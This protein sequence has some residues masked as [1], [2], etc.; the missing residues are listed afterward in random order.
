VLGED[1]L[2]LVTGSP[3]PYFFVTEGVLV[4]LPPDEVKRALAG[5]AERF[6]GAY[7]ALDTY[8]TQ[9]YRRQH[10]MAAKRGIA[11][12]Q[13]PCDDPRSLESLGLRLVESVSLTRPPAALRDRLP[14]R[15]R[16]LLPLAAPV[17]GNFLRVNL[18]QA[19]T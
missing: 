8:P 4:Y 3:A 6:P 13:W 10:T 2:P 18:F 7:V 11:E 14:G 12:W 19:G 17:L 9:S 5:I 1:W 15:Y 16:L